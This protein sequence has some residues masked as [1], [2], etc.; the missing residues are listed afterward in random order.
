VIRQATL[1]DLDGLVELERRCF[2][3]DLIS[4]RSFRYLLTRANAAILVAEEDDG[5]AGYALVLFSRGTALARLYSIAVDGAFRGRGI[6]R[7]LLSAAEAEALA[8]GCVSMRSE[9]RLD[10]QAS[11]ALFEGNGYRRLE[12]IEDYYEDHMGAFRFE[13][14]LAPQLELTQVR[15]PY[16]QQTTDFTCGPACLMMA[17][18]AIDGTLRIDRRLELRLWREA[19]SIFMASGHGGCGPFGL[20]LSAHRRGFGAE[21]FVK[22]RGVFLVDTVR[23]PDK[24]E[25]MRLVEEDFLDR[26]RELDLPLHHRAARFSEVQELFD[27]GGIPLVLISSWRIYQERFPHWVVITGFEER[28]IYVH[29]PYVDVGQAETVADRINMPIARSEFEAMARF[30]RSGQRA[31][32]VV[33]PRGAQRPAATDQARQPAG[34]GRSPVRARRRS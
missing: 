24:K 13:R 9:V 32:L 20:A 17:M 16:Y 1:R 18:K 5:L 10:N 8:L 7:G 12:E 26:I 34:R 27:A 6:G 3:T 30:G 33:W 25:V 2:A 23:D 15:V 19:T 4:R 31:V 14:T 21:L 28:F 22:Q 11:L 29:D